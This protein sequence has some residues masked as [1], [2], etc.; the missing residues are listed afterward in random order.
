MKITGAEI[1][2]G[3]AGY[4]TAKYLR[5]L[6]DEGI[7]GW[8]EYYDHHNG[9]PLDPILLAHIDRLH[10]MDI[11]PSDSIIVGRTLHAATRI[12]T[13]GLN[14]QSIAAVENACVD[15]QAKRL[16]VPA[17]AVLGGRF[18]TELPVYWTHYGSFRAAFPDFY[19]KEFGFAPLTRPEDLARLGDELR[20]T[21]IRAVKTNPI[22]FTDG[23][24]AMYGNGTRIDA[25]L[26][27][28]R[29]V[30]RILGDVNRSLDALEE[31][32]GPDIDVMLDVNFL[33]RPSDV[34][35]L[36][37]GL[38]DRRLSWL[39]VDGLDPAALAELRKSA[40]M[41]I[42]SLEALYGA[43]QLLPYFEARA[44]DVPIVD[45]L[46]NGAQEAIRI[47][48][49]AAAFG[50]DVA[51]HNPV[52]HLG[53]LISAHFAAAIEN[54]RVLELRVDESSAIAGH[55]AAPPTVHDGLLTVP[56]TPGWGAEMLV[57]NLKLQTATGD[58]R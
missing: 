54:L 13:G 40:S 58:A 15:I 19:R 56:S 2:S 45:V 26:F 41:P 23:M 48:H 25:S 1:Y 6:T 20:G 5:V 29:D 9:S 47:A 42:A 36:A 31:S 39:E 12:V 51:I 53:T 43:E 8:S 16:G 28:P 18:R 38:S 22:R 34:R 44:I 50:L 27:A 14:R 46:W 4:R 10:T 37:D 52:G 33:L 21:G 35:R 30:G 57:E 49:L 17:Y 7:D 3:D 24:A 11:D 32:L 55:L